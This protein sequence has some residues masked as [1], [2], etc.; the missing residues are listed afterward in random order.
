[1]SRG[2][3]PENNQ[4]RRIWEGMDGLRRVSHGDIYCADRD[5]KVD[6]GDLGSLGET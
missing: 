3:F 4:E 5:G 6:G 1:M 2:V